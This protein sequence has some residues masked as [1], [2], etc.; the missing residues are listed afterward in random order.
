[1]IIFLDSDTS[2]GKI[3]KFEHK[4]LAIPRT[5]FDLA[6]KSRDP[7][8]MNIAQGLE[9]LKILELTG[10]ENKL[11]MFQV[12][13]QQKI[14]FPFVCLV[15]GLVGSA[16]GSRPQN[17]NRAT[18]FGV[19]VGIIFCYYFFGFF[20]GVF[21]LAGIISPFMAAWLPNFFGLGIGGWLLVK[22]V[23]GFPG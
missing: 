20:I 8:E 1:G 17:T 10:D 4:Q 22:N 23:R 2:Y 18:S 12:R 11:L 7:Y 15:F 19:S 9:Y 16:L 5:G 3:E 6:S 14:S 21:G 13:T